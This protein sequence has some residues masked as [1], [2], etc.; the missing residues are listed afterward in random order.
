VKSLFAMVLI[1]R[2]GCLV[3]A[4]HRWDAAIWISAVVVNP[5]SVARTAG[6]EFSL[7]CSSA[8]SSISCAVPGQL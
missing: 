4:G 8:S 6:T 2:V 1:W 5:L 3:R 7:D